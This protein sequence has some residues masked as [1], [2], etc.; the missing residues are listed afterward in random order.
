MT[1]ITSSTT[2]PLTQPT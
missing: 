1:R 2:H